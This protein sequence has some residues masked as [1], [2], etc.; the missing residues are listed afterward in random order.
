LSDYRLSNLIKYLVQLLKC[1]SSVKNLF[2][3]ESRSFNKVLCNK[4]VV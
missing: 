4:V 2:D 1:E 3:N